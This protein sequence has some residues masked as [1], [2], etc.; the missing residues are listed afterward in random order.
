MAHSVSA[1]ARRLDAH[2]QKV[3]TDFV[4][5]LA[6]AA[7]YTT[8]A[9]W[10]RDSG[11]PAPNLSELRL[12]KGGIDGVNLVRLIRA[13]AAKAGVPPEALAIATARASAEHDDTSLVALR[14]EEIQYAVE[15]ALLLLRA[16]QPPADEPS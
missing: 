8:H 10:S 9:E 1:M 14:L 15:E 3:L 7:G 6:R 12:G 16:A 2:Q 4:N 11:Y 5:A 13:A